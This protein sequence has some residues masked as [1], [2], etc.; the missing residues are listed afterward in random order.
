M[1]LEYEKDYDDRTL[2]IDFWKLLYKSVLLLIEINGIH[3]K[4]GPQTLRWADKS[5]MMLHFKSSWGEKLLSLE[6]YIFKKVFSWN[7]AI[8]ESNQMP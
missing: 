2:V 1:I 6:P 5:W 3:K 4:D 8:Q 7:T